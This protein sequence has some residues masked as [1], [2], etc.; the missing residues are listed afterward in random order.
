MS[1]PAVMKH[2]DT[3]A[4]AGLISRT[5]TGRTVTCR[6]TL[7]P[8]EEA[9]RWLDEHQRFWSERLDNLAKLVEEKP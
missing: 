5:K 8:M 3:L 1:L 9:M 4:T 6:P 7:G 2:L